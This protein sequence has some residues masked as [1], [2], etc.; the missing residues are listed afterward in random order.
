MNNKNELSIVDSALAFV[1]AFLMSQAFVFFASIVITMILTMAGLDGSAIESM[2]DSSPWVYSILSLASQAGFFVLFIYYFKKKQD[3]RQTVSFKKPKFN[4]LTALI[5]MLIGL[6]T[7]YAVVGVIQYFDLF[8]DF[9]HFKKSPLPFKIDSVQ[10]LIL[11]LITFGIIPPIC[12]E[13]LFRGVIFKGL[14]SKGAAFA[15]LV[16]ALMFAIFHLSAEQFVYPFLFGILLAI[17]MWNTDNIVYCILAH[18]TNNIVNIISQYVTRNEIAETFTHSSGFL[19][20]TIILFAAWA[21]GMFFLFKKGQKS[22]LL[23]TPQQIKTEPAISDVEDNIV[24]DN[25]TLQKRNPNA[26]FVLCLLIMTA[27]WIISFSFSF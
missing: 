8:L 20:V 24:E 12:E 13:L 16:S 4:Y 26:V 19:I 10:N 6:I 1:L 17:I 2:L 7:I 23:S 25:F 11:G 18:A 21:V 14:K 3:V 5:Y 15:I 22:K 9:I 27:F